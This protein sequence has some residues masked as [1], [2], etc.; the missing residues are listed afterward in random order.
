MPST[1]LL[2]LPYPD[3]DDALTDYP[4]LAQLLA[5]TLEDKIGMV[6]ISD[7]LLGADAAS[8]SIAVPAT[9]DHLLLVAYARSAL[10]ATFD[11]LNMRLNSLSTALYSEGGI[12]ATNTAAAVHWANN[13]QTDSEI[14]YI[15]GNSQAGWGQARM[16]MLNYR[17]ARF[18]RWQYQSINWTDANG[19]DQQVCRVGSGTF[20]AAGSDAADFVAS[21]LVF[22]G[23]GNLRAGSRFTLYGLR[24]PA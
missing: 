20:D 5:E 1:P 14:G 4:A 16:E 9:F 24:G 19:G 22:A 8:V 3:G 2:G 12:S 6:E 13:A 7:T 21:L 10:A 15:P 23:G 17:A 11:Q 18:R